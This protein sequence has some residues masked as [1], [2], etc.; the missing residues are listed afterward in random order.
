MWN[1][2]YVYV[3]NALCCMEK[4]AVETSTFMM[5]DSKA[6]DIINARKPKKVSSILSFE[7]DEKKNQANIK[8]HGISFEIAMRVFSDENRLEDYDEAHSIDED[9]YISIGMVRDILYVVYTDRGEA[10]RII[11]ARL[12]DKDERSRYYEQFR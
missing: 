7:W 12:A 8:K 5:N 3:G 1:S 11:S 10:I 9:R 4:I 6:Y 2:G